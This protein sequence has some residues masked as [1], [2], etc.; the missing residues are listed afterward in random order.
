MENAARH[1]YFVALFEAAKAVHSSLVLKDV[2]H[3]IARTSA[4]TLG[5]K[6]ASV[7]LLDPGTRTLRLYASYGLSEDYLSKGPVSLRSSEI[8]RQALN[9]EAVV[10]EDVSKDPRFQYRQEAV[11][12]GIRSVLCVP[13]MLDRQGAGVL[14]VYA[15]ERRKFDQGEV[16]LL[17]AMATLGALAIRNAEQFNQVQTELKGLEEY[18]TAPW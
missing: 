2:L 4:D 18:V 3:E 9:G 10:L 13:L 7:R 6:A 15:S 1:P 14:R 12:E 8:D 5:A 11:Q 16:D 17:T